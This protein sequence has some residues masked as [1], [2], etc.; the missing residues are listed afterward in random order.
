MSACSSVKSDKEAIVKFTPYGEKEAVALMTDDVYKSYSDSSAGVSKFYEKILELLI[1]YQFKDLGFDK[2]ELKY[3][4]IE[5]WAK[6]QVQD[7]KDK[8]KSDAKSNG[9]SYD[10]EWDKILEN[11]NVDNANE[12]REK[13]I[14]EKEKEVMKDWYATN[15]ANAEALKNEF[16][17]IDEN[18]QKVNSDVKSA[19]PYHIRHILVKV[20][21]AG[22]L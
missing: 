18:G 17:G 11:N 21:E 4:E 7:Q 6:N 9:T 14:Y 2:G 1:R 5:D 20:D 12:L 3:K 15:D 22:I 16:I 10:T 8:A 19:M 13:F